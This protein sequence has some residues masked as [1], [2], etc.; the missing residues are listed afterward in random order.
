MFSVLCQHHLMPASGYSK[1][2]TTQNG[3]DYRHIFQNERDFIMA[4]WC[5]FEKFLKY[6][7]FPKFLE[8]LPASQ[9][10][11][12]PAKVTAGIFAPATDQ[13]IVIG[14]SISMSVRTRKM[15]NYA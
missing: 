4:I 10:A 14:L 15:V 11:S 9:P 13:S 12:Q 1:N 5:P 2:N 6:P 8:F 3:N 7:K